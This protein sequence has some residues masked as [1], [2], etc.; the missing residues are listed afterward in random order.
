M[1]EVLRLVPV[2]ARGV[3][4]H[5]LRPG[6]IGSLDVGTVTEPVDGQREM[7]IEPG[8]VLGDL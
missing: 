2:G 8:V 1:L 4:R 7:G 3:A 5:P 6:G